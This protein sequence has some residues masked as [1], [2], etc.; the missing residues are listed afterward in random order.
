MSFAVDVVK[1]V[2]DIRILIELDISPVNDQ[3]VNNGAGIWVYNLEASYP[4]VDDTL[5]D[6]F[7]ASDLTNVGSVVSDGAPL[8]SVALVDTLTPL[9][10]VWDA[11]NNDLYICLQNYDEPGIH[12]VRVG[13]VYGFSYDEF[14]PAG[15]INSQLYEGRLSGAPS[16]TLARDPLFFG[17]IQ[18][19]GGSIPIVNMDGK[20]DTF[21]QDNNIYGNEVRIFIG[22]EDLDYSDYERIFTGYVDDVSVGEEVMDITITDR[23]KRLTRAIEIT[24]TA[25]NPVTTIRD[26]LTAFFNASYDTDYFDVTEWDQATTDV[27]ADGLTVSLNMQEPEPGIDVIE[28]L[29]LAAAGILY[30]T[31]DGKYSF[32]QID[33]DASAAFTVLSND[34]LNSKTIN[35]N[36]GDVVSSVRV[37]YARDWVTSGTQYT[38]E[39]YDTHEASVFN[40]YQ[41]YNEQLFDTFLDTKTAADNW[42]A[43]FYPWFIDVHGETSV[44]VP[45]KYYDDA[46][47]TEITDVQIQRPQK[48]ML[49]TVGSEIQS[50]TWNIDTVPTITLGVRFV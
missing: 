46:V 48:T 17:R 13:L 3:W 19:G 42:A 8:V 25:Q 37:G 15:M 12:D 4:W 21:A 39:T 2:S 14:T 35:Y 38:Y 36:T 47:I 7:T 50:I 41:I 20:Y 5:L 32:R 16:V 28:S 43:L 1:S 31:A 22:F 33:P 40:A 10:F 49:G 11:T 26:I 18:F 34:V 9:E 24:A 45:I 44:Q 27:A 29:C 30:I 6:G 23:R